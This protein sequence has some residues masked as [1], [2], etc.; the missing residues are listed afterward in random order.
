M[1]TTSPLGAQTGCKKYGKVMYHEQYFI[2]RLKE[3][4]GI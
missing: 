1:G 2:K 3:I 4:K